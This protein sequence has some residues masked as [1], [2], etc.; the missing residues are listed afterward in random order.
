MK[1]LTL[2]LL[3]LL[4]THTLQAEMID[5]TLKSQSILEQSEIFYDQQ[6]HSFKQVQKLPF[7]PMKTD[8]VNRSFDAQTVVWIKMK[9]NNSST[10]SIT[11][12]IEVD[13][14]ILSSII[15]YGPNRLEITGVLHVQK[16]RH[17]INPSFN[18]TLLAHQSKTLYLRIHNQTT[19]LQ[20]GVALLTPEKMH[21]K[22]QSRQYE[23]MLFLGIIGAFFLYAL[24]LFIYSRDRSYLLYTLYLSTL[25]FQ[26]MTY[27]GMLPLHA[28]QWF[29]AIDNLIVVPK[30]GMMIITAIWFAQSFLKTKHFPTIH[31]LYK[32]LYIFVFLQM[33]LFGT[34]WFYYPEVTVL[35]GLLFIIFNTFAGFYVYHHGNKQA[36]FF[37]AGWMILIFAYILFIFDALGFI[38]IM[39]TFPNLIMWATALEALFLLLAFVDRLSLLQEQ[40]E[41]LNRELLGAYALRQ[42]I[43]EKSVE[44]KTAELTK[45]LNQKELLLKEL[46]HRVKNNLQLILSL[47]RLQKGLKGCDQEKILFQQL[48]GRIRAI[49]RTHELLYQNENVE[50]IDMELYVDSYVEEMQQTI[51]NDR[52]TIET[53]ID[54][55]LPLSSAVYIGLVINELV[56][57]AVKYA[58]GEHKGIIHIRMRQKEKNYT[59]EVCDEGKGYTD[60]SVN[61]S[62]LGMTLVKTLIEDQ[63]EGNIELNT[64]RGTH[65]IMRFSL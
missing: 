64:N 18:L 10:T 57:N 38:S 49:A 2:M 53:D 31:R 4:F 47:L 59:L 58:Y 29:S 34:Q 41:A 3:L 61:G 12:V 45:A 20:F 46:H 39:H 50:L 32:Y 56:S 23:I 42:E 26:Q 30:V 21:H 1:R 6:E 60:E 43:I 7:S 25:L 13:N 19:T 55:V 48:E 17:Y 37:I 9:F 51:D 28:P 11:R 62:S 5:V 40:K 44:K 15:L 36:R 52:I 65:Y 33:P 24:F 16:D 63:L 8:Y 35:T 14:P 22:D 54:A 27:L